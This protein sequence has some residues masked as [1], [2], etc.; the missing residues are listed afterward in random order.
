MAK[1]I[2]LNINT[3]RPKLEF[4]TYKKIKK[5]KIKK[6][7]TCKLQLNSTTATPISMSPDS[8]Q[9]QETPALHAQHIYIYTLMYHENH[10]IM[11]HTP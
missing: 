5:K 6:K 10:M 7:M 8:P 2:Q 11:V 4:Q 3:F 1:A 9:K